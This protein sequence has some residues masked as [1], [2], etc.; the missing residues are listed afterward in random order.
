MGKKS[1]IACLLL[2]VI[3][4]AGHPVFA[5]KDHKGIA[6]ILAFPEKPIPLPTDPTIW[7]KMAR[8]FDFD[9]D[10]MWMVGHAGVMILDPEAGEAEYV[11]FG[12]YDNRE[13]DDPA[14]Q[15]AFSTQRLTPS[16]MLILLISADF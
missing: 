15:M 3:I 12:R 11:D 5:G 4:I 9:N 1:P 6:V 16:K 13:A 10:D 8:L 14:D 7:N 2:V